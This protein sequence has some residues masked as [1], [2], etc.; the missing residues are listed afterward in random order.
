M[1]GRMLDLRS[2]ASLSYSLP[3]NAFVFTAILTVGMVLSWFWSTSVAPKL[4]RFAV[5]ETILSTAYFTIVIS[6]V[7]VFLQVR[8]QFIYFQF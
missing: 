2:L 5:A 6:F 1:W 8:A 4:Q 7:F 3:V